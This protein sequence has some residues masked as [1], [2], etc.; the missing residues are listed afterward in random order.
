M[1][2]RNPK[3]SCNLSLP[4]LDCLIDSCRTESGRLSINLRNEQR[5]NRKERGTRRWRSGPVGKIKTQAV[6]QNVALYCDWIIDI[7]YEYAALLGVHSI[8][9][10]SL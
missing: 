3:R 8:T 4:V 10:Q 5:S 2:S 1:M 7:H 9:L 6:P